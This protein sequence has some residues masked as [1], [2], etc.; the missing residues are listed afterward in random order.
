MRSG[1]NNTEAV[2]CP[3]CVSSGGAQPPLVPSPVTLT[4]PLLKV[5]FARLFPGG[6]TSPLY[7]LIF[8]SVD[9]Q[10][11]LP[12]TGIRSITVITSLVLKGSQVGPAGAP[13]SWSLRR[14]HVPSRLGISLF[15]GTA[16]HFR[17]VLHFPY[18]SPAV[19]NYIQ[20]KT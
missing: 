1:R 5:V 12:F 18:S 3:L 6:I 7:L 8:I 2:P 15:S 11:Q 19:E 13:S 16:R 14:A 9:V 10:F 4:D 17:F 20:V